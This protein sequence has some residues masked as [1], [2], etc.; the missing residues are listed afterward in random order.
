MRSNVDRHRRLAA[1]A[2]GLA[3]LLSMPIVVTQYGI[4]GRILVPGDAASTARNIVAHE[5]LF[6]AGT[7]AYVLYGL[8]CLALISALYVL[9]RAAGPGL[10]F[11]AAVT[12]LPYAGLWLL[13]AIDRFAALRLVAQPVYGAALGGSGAQT[14]ALLFLSGLDVYYVGLPFYGIA[15]SICG[16][17][18]LR[19]HFI[20]R[21]LALATLLASLWCT[22]CAL[23]YLVAPSLSNVIGLSW[24][25]V[26]SALVDLLLSLWLLVRAVPLIEAAS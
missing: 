1:R 20:P 18:W 19:S 9:L 16:Y 13:V 25:D 4:E 2:A 3:F 17:L 12:R 26:P 15:A 23:V 24:F 5:G 8:G 6:R 11:F 10:A 22:G 7:L 14:L 21:P